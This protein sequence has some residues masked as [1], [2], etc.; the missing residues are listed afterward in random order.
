[1]AGNTSEWHLD[2]RVPITI[3][4]AFIAQT[5]ILTY[6]GTSWKADIENRVNMLE[7]SDDKASSHDTRIVVLEQ[8]ML[9]IREDLSEIK[10]L[11]RMQKLGQAEEKLNQQVQPQ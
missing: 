9:R 2:K 8:G 5:L 10:T 6:I 1:M 4:L 7:R 11:I 3:I